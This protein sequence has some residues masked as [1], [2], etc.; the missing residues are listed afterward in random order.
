MELHHNGTLLELEV[1]CLYPT[2]HSPV[3][4]LYFYVCVATTSSESDNSYNYHE[5]SHGA[6]KLCVIRSVK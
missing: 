2:P 1:R 5:E 3:D 6:S 4:S